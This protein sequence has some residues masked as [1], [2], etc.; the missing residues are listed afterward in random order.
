M[1]FAP[2]ALLATTSFLVVAHP[3]FSQTPT[4]PFVVGSASAGPGQTSYGALEITA[5][6]DAATTIPIAIVRGIRPGPV[7]AFIAGSHGTEYTSTVALTQL[8]ARIDPRALSPE[9]PSSSRFSTSHRSN[10]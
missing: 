4:D 10:K 7:V 5:G 1:R 3:T 8:I 6:A 9:R 2:V